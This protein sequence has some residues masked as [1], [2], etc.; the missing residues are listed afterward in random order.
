MGPQTFGKSLLAIFWP[1]ND[2]RDAYNTNLAN[3]TRLPAY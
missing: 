3:P 1:C 2:Y